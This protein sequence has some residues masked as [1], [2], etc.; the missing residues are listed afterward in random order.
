MNDAWE[1]PVCKEISN[2]TWHCESA[3]MGTPCACVTYRL[4]QLKHVLMLLLAAAAA[5][6][7]EAL[8]FPDASPDSAVGV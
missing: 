3:S 2:Q 7:A 6:A 1:C 8:H 4:G 5:A